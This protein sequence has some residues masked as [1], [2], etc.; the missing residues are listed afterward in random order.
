MVLM[1]SND[2]EE[3]FHVSGREGGGG[4]GWD[5]GINVEMLYFIFLLEKR[6]P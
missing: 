5:K 1:T 2:H 3:K 4:G 6:F